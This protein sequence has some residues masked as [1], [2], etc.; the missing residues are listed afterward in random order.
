MTTIGKTTNDLHNISNCRKQF[1]INWKGWRLYDV[2]LSVF[3]SSPFSVLHLFRFFTF[4][5]SLPFS[6]L[7]HVRLLTIFGPS[8]ALTFPI[9]TLC[10]LQSFDIIDLL[11]QFVYT[12]SGIFNGSALLRK[13]FLLHIAV[14]FIIQLADLQVILFDHLLAGGDLTS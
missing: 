14:Q 5:S 8:P 13:G 12:M 2:T 6:V 1:P 11:L 4:F 3:G 9:L 10:H 7:Y